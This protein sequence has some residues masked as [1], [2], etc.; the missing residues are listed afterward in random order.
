MGLAIEWHHVVLAVR[1]EADVAHQ[2]EIVIP[3]R[4]AERPIEDLDGAFLVSLKDFIVGTDHALWRLHQAFATGIIA[5][6]GNER[7][8]SGFSLLARRPWLDRGG[9]RPHMIR[10]ALLWP[11]LYVGDLRVHDGSLRSTGTQGTGGV[12]GSAASVNRSGPIPRPKK[13][14][15]RCIPIRQTRFGLLRAPRTLL[16]APH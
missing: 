13:A 2:N 7:T 11:R 1:V 5:G 16:A 9:C 15:G 14:A 4:L 12:T 6:V 10:Q 3:A 8:H